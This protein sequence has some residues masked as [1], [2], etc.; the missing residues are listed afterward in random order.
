MKYKASKKARLMPGF[1]AS[2]IRCY[3]FVID[4][5]EA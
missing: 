1:F 5:A 4:L 3:P 2:E